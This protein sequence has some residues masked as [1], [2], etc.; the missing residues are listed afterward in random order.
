MSRK[1]RAPKLRC[2][3][4]A[5]DGGWGWI[6]VLHFFMV[7]VLVMGMLKSFGFFFVAFQEEFSENAERI[8]WI[9]SIMSSLRL[10]AGPLASVSCGRLGERGTAVLG[11]VIV[12]AGFFVSVLAQS[13]PFLYITLGVLVGL[14]FALIY[15]SASI[16]TA[17][18]FKSRLSTAYAISRSG[19]GLTFALAPFTQ[20]LLDKY[21]WRGALLILG[22]LM[23][24]LI[25]SGMLLRPIHLLDDLGSAQIEKSAH[26]PGNEDQ[27]GDIAIVCPAQGER[28]GAAEQ[29]QNRWDAA[30]V[31]NAAHTYEGGDASSGRRTGVD[32][33]ESTDLPNGG[34]KGPAAPPG[35]RATPTRAGSPCSDGA[36]RGAEA[37]SERRRTAN[38]GNNPQ[39][40]SAR[41]KCQRVHVEVADERGATSCPPC[42]GQE[43]KSEEK[44]LDISLLREPLFHVY[45]WSVVFSQLA[46]FIPYF[47]LA[48]RAQTLGIDPM[49][50][51]LIISMA[52]ITET[53]TQLA[54]GW[55]ADRNY[56]PKIR[57]LTVY[58]LLCGI[59]TLLSPLA[60]TFTSLMAYAIVFAIFCGGY[61]ALLLP[62]LVDLLG[63]Q[64]VRS[65]FGLSMFFV[66]F[67]CLMG[68]PTAGWLYDITHTYD[69]SFFLAGTCYLIA[70]VPLLLEPLAQARARHHDTARPLGTGSPVPGL[71]G[72]SL[73]PLPGSGPPTSRG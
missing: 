47:H 39:R 63:V 69:S 15:Q 55:V 51:S 4:D 60:T 31:L 62:V 9:G 41:R 12:A 67:G 6:I 25:P 13:V 52:G 50:A 29:E 2:Y 59:T 11:G 70:A 38:S 18:Y 22:A 3:V 32:T 16:M 57:Y 45:T 44:L 71:S 8:S 5:P 49:K 42:G 68:P 36:S 19:M 23:L 54:S 7:N 34:G 20:M 37:E 33:G 1:N 40:V 28:R 64:R 73:G 30:P 72:E 26:G 61:M 48:A 21:G 14:G 56:V 66:G 27:A 10:M 43:P 65:A 46:Y 17:R 24:N 58:L 35:R 53:L